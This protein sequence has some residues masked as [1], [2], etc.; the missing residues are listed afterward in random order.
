METAPAPAVNIA[1]LVFVASDVAVTTIAYVPAAV[2]VHAIL[3]FPL[4]AQPW[5]EVGTTVKLNPVFTA[6]TSKVFD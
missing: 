6:V 2:G 1:V 4:F 3:S 5:P